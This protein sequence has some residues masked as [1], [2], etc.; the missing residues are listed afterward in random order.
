MTYTIKGLI[1]FISWYK[2]TS[3]CADCGLFYHPACM[4]L[5][6]VPERGQKLGVVKDFAKRRD[7]EGLWLELA[8]CDV[9]CSNCH[10]LRTVN[11]GTSNISKLKI[12]QGK[13][14][15][16]NTNRASYKRVI[17]QAHRA[18]ISEAQRKRKRVYSE[19]AAA[20]MKA[21]WADSEFKLKMQ[22]SGVG[23]RGPGKKTRTI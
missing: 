16:S 20:K 15:K 10:R 18:S 14:G 6:H 9:V 5:D 19:S 3:P 17:S 4:D 1:A 21:K 12:S 11:R 7:V 2:S 8:K 22:N 13:R 23:K